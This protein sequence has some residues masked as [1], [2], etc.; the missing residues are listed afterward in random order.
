MLPISDGLTPSR[1]CAFLVQCREDGPEADPRGRCDP[2][3]VSVPLRHLLLLTHKRVPP[4]EV[5]RYPLVMCDPRICK[6]YCCEIAR[7]LRTVDEMKKAAS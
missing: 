2:L 6:G 3:V 1:P 5:S 4:E 7:V